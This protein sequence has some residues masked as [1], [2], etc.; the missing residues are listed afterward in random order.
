ML[1]QPYLDINVN[2]LCHLLIV[3]YFNI[4]LVPKLPP[5]IFP[6]FSHVF[7]LFILFLCMIDIILYIYISIY[8]CVCV[9]VCS[10][11]WSKI[12]E[13]LMMS[14]ERC[15]DSSRCSLRKKWR[16]LLVRTAVHSKESEE[17]FLF[18]F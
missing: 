13:Q 17:C 6:T 3:H 12:S 9:C 18:S 14:Y 10:F 15:Y 11:R 16:F 7:Q 5:F 8:V 1:S 2:H 4:V